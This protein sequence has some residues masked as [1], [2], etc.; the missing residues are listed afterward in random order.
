MLAAAGTVANSRPGKGLATAMPE[1]CIDL[2][3]T[4]TELFPS[5]VRCPGFLRTA[6]FLFCS[7]GRGI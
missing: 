1:K 7:G 4:A 5:S 2:H 3:L 6:Y